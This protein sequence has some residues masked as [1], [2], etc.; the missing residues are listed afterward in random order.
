MAT[1][2]T[3]K[4]LGK[5]LEDFRASH[6]NDFI[7]PNKIRSALD[8]LGN[9]WM[10]EADFIK[11]CAVNN[12][13]FARYREQFIDFVVTVPSSSAG[14]GTRR[15]WSGTKQMATKMREMVGA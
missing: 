9:S 6:D 5:S 2:K 8:K 14:G 12:T 4:V 15:V 3:E 10:Y 7:V 11:L 1:E 13:L